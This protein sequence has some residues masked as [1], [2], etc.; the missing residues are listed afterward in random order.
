[1]FNSLKKTLT[2]AKESGGAGAQPGAAA[3]EKKEISK[4]E[5]LVYVKKQVCDV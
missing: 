2:P 4:E 1:M 3:P 5:L